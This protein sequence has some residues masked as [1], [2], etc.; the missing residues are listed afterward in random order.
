MKQG[1]KPTVRQELKRID[2]KRA[3][4]AEDAALRGDHTKIVRN[5]TWSADDRQPPLLDTATLP[6]G[7][8]K[9]KKIIEWCPKRKALGEGNKRH[10]YIEKEESFQSWI[11][12]EPRMRKV[13]YCMYCR[14]KARAWKFKKGWY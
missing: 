2:S 9:R 4:A 1:H 13:K 10:Y 12:G 14:H 8:K 11:D 7:Q 6:Q 5:R 3:R